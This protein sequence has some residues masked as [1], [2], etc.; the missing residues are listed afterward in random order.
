RGD[1]AWASGVVEGGNRGP[2]RD[3]PQ[4]GIT[5]EAVADGEEP[6]VRAE[7]NRVDV[8]P[9]RAAEGGDPLA[10]GGLPEVD[11]ALLI[12]R[13]D[14]LAVGAE[15]HRDDAGAA[16]GQP[17]GRTAATRHHDDRHDDDEGGD[18][19]D[20]PAAADPRSEAA[21]PGGNPAHPR[22]RGWLHGRDY[23]TAQLVMN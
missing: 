14:D 12:G 19:C 4:R 6:A 1:E 7:G 17:H 11:E 5:A 9:P 16:A 3:A 22:G 15:R 20:A 8:G 18:R 10:G 21:R 13:S 23:H 2:G